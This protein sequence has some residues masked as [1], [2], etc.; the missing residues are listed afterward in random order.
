MNLIRHW[1][2]RFQVHKAFPQTTLDK[3][4][5]SIAAGEE[6]HL[7]EVCFAIEGGLPWFEALNY[8]SARDRAEAAAALAARLG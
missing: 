4:Q 3:I 6:D 1:L 7:G 5:S 8:T 2:A